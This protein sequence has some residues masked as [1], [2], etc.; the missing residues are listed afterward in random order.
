MTVIACFTGVNWE[1]EQKETRGCV[2]GVIRNL[3]AVTVPTARHHP[4]AP[5]SIRPTERTEIERATATMS[6]SDDED[7]PC[8]SLSC[9]HRFLCAGFISHNDMI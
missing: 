2:Q 3:W 8:V 1:N 6:M 5:V 7:V 9:H 4:R